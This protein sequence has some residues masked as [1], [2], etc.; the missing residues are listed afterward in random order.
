MINS[1]RLEG[2]EKL[3]EFPKDRS[4]VSRN[5]FSLSHFISTDETRYQPRNERRRCSDRCIISYVDDVIR[6]N[7]SSPA[8][9]K[10]PPT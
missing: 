9:P 7:V 5:R 8:P 1:F 3:A 2:S 6:A 10:I 4:P